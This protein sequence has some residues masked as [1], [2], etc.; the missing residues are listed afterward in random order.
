[1]PSVEFPPYMPQDWRLDF[2][3]EFA[4]NGVIA[5][6]PPKVGTAF[7]VLVPQVDQDGIDQ[8]GIAVPEAAAL[9]WGH[10]PDGIINC[11]FFR[12]SSIWQGCLEA[13]FR[14]P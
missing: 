6:E 14:F 10:S 2:G 4:K 7:K 8:G 1:M 13:S 3:P 12:T 9:R 5:H 11:P